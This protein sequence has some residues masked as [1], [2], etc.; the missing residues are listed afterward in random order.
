MALCRSGEIAASARVL[1]WHTGGLFN[2]IVNG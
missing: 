2:Y 1:F